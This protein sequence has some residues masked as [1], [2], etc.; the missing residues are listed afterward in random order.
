MSYFQSKK[1]TY[2]KS[3]EWIK[4]N[5]NLVDTLTECR[6]DEFSFLVKILEDKRIVWLGENG[7]G[8]AEHNI[9][10][11]KLID[12]LYHKMGFKVIAFESGLT[13]CF[14]SNYEKDELSV[15]ELMDNSVFS[16]WKT[17]ETYPLF[18]LIKE[19]I[20][21]K[22]IGFDFQPT[23]KQSMMI[24]FLDALNIDFP[25]EFKQNIQNVEKVTF[26]WYYRIGKYKARRKRVPKDIFHKYKSIQ[27]EQ[28]ELIDRLHHIL[29]D[30]KKDFINNGLDVPYKVIQKGLDNKRLFFNHLIDNNRDYSKFRDQ[31]MAANLEWVCN[32]LYP[33]EKIIIWAHNAHIY[34]NY[35]TITKY[36]PM[37]SLISK[38]LMDDSYYIGLFMYE[39]E[40]AL[41]NR[42][43]YKIAHPPKKSLEDYMSHTDSSISFLDFS[44]VTPQP[45]NKW[46]FKKTLILEHGTMQKLI[47]PSEQFDGIF[48]VKKVSPPRYL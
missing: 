6:G 10:K 46:I 17:K 23:T 26:D 43:V 4:E 33:N 5:A 21:L 20:E 1:K 9:I 18:E 15:G 38:A 12:F 44:N 27:K 30:L 3:V 47:V 31:I 13:E 22:L 11:T 19:N 41:M 16:V 37:G 7:H 32:E 29:I 40:A 34:K 28:N 35:Q 39:G 48:F 36:R 8:I 24:E 2:K 45:F 25:L 14:T 42:T